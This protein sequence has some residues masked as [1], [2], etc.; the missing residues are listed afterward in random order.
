MFIYYKFDDF[1]EFKRFVN[2]FL[3]KEKSIPLS[4]A[5]IMKIL[6]VLQLDE[7][8]Q[9]ILAD[10]SIEFNPDKKYYFILSMNHW[11]LVYRKSGVFLYDSNGFTHLEWKNKYPESQLIKLLDSLNVDQSDGSPEQK[12][13]TTCGYHCL[14]HATKV[15]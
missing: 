11:F 3:C 5:D 1:V 9:I 15:D 8:S 7:K 13:Q 2:N 4:D 14:Y 10:E 6:K 12:L